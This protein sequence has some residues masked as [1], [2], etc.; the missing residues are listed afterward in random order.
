MFRNVNQ[1]DVLALLS[2]Q[3]PSYML[4]FSHPNAMRYET[5][6]YGVHPPQMAI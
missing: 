6:L 2:E 4:E 5:Y 3:P 1:T